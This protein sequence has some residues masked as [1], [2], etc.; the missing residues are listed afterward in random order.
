[1]AI[2]FDSSSNDMALNMGDPSIYQNMEAFTLSAWIKPQGWGENNFGRIAAKSDDFSDDGWLFYVD[3]SNADATISFQ[4]NRTF[5]NTQ[6]V[7]ADDM[8]A[9]NEWAHVVLTYLHASGAKGYVNGVEIS[10]TSTTAGSGDIWGDDGI[11]LFIGNREAAGRGF[12][13]LIEEVRVYDRVLSLGEIG[14]LYA[15]RGSDSIWQNRIGHWPLTGKAPGVVLGTD[16]IHD[17][18]IQGNH[19]VSM[20][21]STPGAEG[22]R[23]QRSATWSMS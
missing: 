18:T 5:T 22:I 7:G 15:A 23:R 13:G 8:L 1:M 17:I 9:L 10:Y 21:A 14:Q 2:D 12:D 6:F 11:D 20:Y 16:P 4:N 3:D 19:G